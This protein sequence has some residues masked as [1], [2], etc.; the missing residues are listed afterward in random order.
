M[1]KKR[2][3]GILIAGVIALLLVVAGLGWAIRVLASTASPNEPLTTALTYQG[4]LTAV[5]EPANGEFDFTFDLY[6]GEYSTSPPI[7]TI[8]LEDVMVAGGVFTVWLDYGP[9]VFDGNE[10]WLEISVRKGGETGTYTTLD[11]RQELT[12]APHAI[13]AMK[14][15]EV[16]WTGVQNRPFGLDDGDDDT[17]YTAGFGLDLEGTTLNVMTDTLQA[18][19]KGVCPEGS[20]IHLIDEDGFIEC[21]SDAPLQRNIKPRENISSTLD[22]HPGWYTDITIGTDGL[23]VIS[24]FDSYYM[25]LE[26]AHCLDISCVEST[27]QIP[28]EE[29]SSQTGFYSSMAIG[30]DS[31]PVISFYVPP[32]SAL[33]ITHCLDPSCSNAT[34]HEI[35]S[36]EDIGKYSSIT[37]GPDGNPIV[38][39]FNETNS[40]LQIAHCNLPDC[41]DSTIS[42]VDSS[43]LVGKYTA[44]VIGADGLPLI[45]YFDENNGDLKV[46][47]CEDLFCTSSIT[48]TV[49]MGNNVGKYS[50]ITIGNDW[51]PII[52]YYDEFNGDLKVAHCDN[53]NCTNATTTTLDEDGN[54]GRFSSITIGSNGLA[55]ISYYDET[56]GDLKIAHCNNISCTSAVVKSL[57]M[58]G[59]VGMHT[60]ITLGV[61]GLPLIT[62]LDN[63]TGK[64]NV[65]H[66][67]DPI[68]VSNWRRR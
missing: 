34:Y 59:D 45:S 49:D 44:I 36:D 55:I 15:G 20:S 19:L 12:P 35:D 10:R 61:D 39:F 9:D 7:D 24:Y 18:R 21:L 68:C 48:S 6:P 37:I 50:S 54:V 51:L 5:G 31:L 27:N 40:N 52:S 56:H 1:D 33:W 8:A 11:G 16:D 41:S 66:C 2:M 28:I 43:E 47:H 13:Y 23:P 42:T 64:L 38:S 67:S 14:S 26:T 65:F 32:A 4:F 30:I 3:Y 58:V 60:S 29:P 25:R 46:A 62:Y 17:T 57:D 53:V 22:Y 63:S